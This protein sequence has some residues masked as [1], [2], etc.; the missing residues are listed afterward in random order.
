MSNSLDLDFYTDGSIIDIGTERCSMTFALLQTNNNAPPVRFISSIEQWCSSTRVELAAVLVALLISPQ[1]ASINIFTDSKSVID[2]YHHLISPSHNHSIRNFFKNSTNNFIWSMILD[3]VR[4]KVIS[5]TFHKVKAHSGDLNND[6][7][8]SLAK[9]YHGSQ[10]PPFIFNISNFDFISYFPC[11]KNIL[12]ENNL[13]HFISDISRNIGFEK[14]LNLHRNIRYIN[15]EIDWTTTFFI[16]N[17]EENTTETSFFASNRKS[18]KIKFFLFEELPTVEHVKLRRPDLY[19]GWNCPSC[20]D[21]RETFNHIWVCR[22]HRALIDTIIFNRKKELI[23]L[24]HKYGFSS[25]ITTRDLTHSTLWSCDHT[26][27]LNFIDVIKGVVPQFLVLKINSFVHNINITRQILSIFYNNIYLDI[28]NEIW[29]PRCERMVV[30]EFHAGIDRKKK[31][32][33]CDSNFIR[34][35]TNSSR[36]TFNFDGLGMVNHIELGGEWLQH[37]HSGFWCTVN[38]VSIFLIETRSVLRLKTFSW[39]W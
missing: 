16:L 13:R 31:H 33:Q 17:D 20:K 1:F 4:Q 39:H 30:D 5:L 8:D 14:F 18:H 36:N 38:Y 34:S 7:V 35:S 12:I 3:I 21:T 19:T 2:C 25:R 26:N 29:K 37:Y 28:N 23:S 10:D 22:C 24:V 27:N 6:L 32:K 11:W 15:S 9:N